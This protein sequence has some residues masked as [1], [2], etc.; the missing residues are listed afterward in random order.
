[1]VFAGICQATRSA[2]GRFEFNLPAGIVNHGAAED[3]VNNH[4][5]R[6]TA[7]VRHEDMQ[8]PEG[9]NLQTAVDELHHEN[10]FVF[11]EHFMDYRADP[12]LD[13]YYFQIAWSDLEG[14]KNL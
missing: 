12:L 5:A 9:R 11:R 10:V 1:M 2:T 6:E 8:Q 4:F 13:R 14:S 3:D 7:R